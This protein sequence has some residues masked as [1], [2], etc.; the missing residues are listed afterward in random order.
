MNFPLEFKQPNA[1]IIVSYWKIT[2]FYSTSLLFL[3]MKNLRF[4]KQVYI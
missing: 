2:T 1:N 4:I 3:R